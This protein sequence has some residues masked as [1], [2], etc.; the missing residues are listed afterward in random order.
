M[1]TPTARLALS[2]LLALLSACQCGSRL[3]QVPDGLRVEPAAVDFGVLQPGAVA[4]AEVTL[5]NEGKRTLELGFSLE[6]AA[7]GA[8]AVSKGRL[9][10]PS[11]GRQAIGLQYRAGT[12][13]SVDRA[14][15]RIAEGE[16]E[17]EVLLRGQT[18]VPAQPDGGLV[19]GPGP[20]DA[21]GPRLP[22]DAGSC[23]PLTCA[24]AGRTCGAL[25]DGCGGTLSCGA[26]ASGSAC[27][28]QAG[29]CVCQGGARE[30][31]CGDGVD[32]DCDGRIDCVDPDCSGAP[33]CAPTT[34]SNQGDVRLSVGTR[35]AN[36]PDL[37]FDGT[38]FGVAW[39]EFDPSTA[40]IDFAFTRLSRQQQQVGSAVKLTTDGRGAHPPR[41]A[42]SGDWAIAAVTAAAPPSTA[43]GAV[44][45]RRF[46]A[47]GQTLGAPLDT[48]VGWPGMLAEGAA[49]GAWGLLWGSGGIGAAAATLTQLDQTGRVGADLPLLGSA[50]GEGVDYGDL[51]WDGAGWGLVWTAT[52]PATSTSMVRFARITAAGAV[53]VAPL[54]L[55]PSGALYP[56]LAWTGARYGV[57]WQAVNAQGRQDIFFAVVDPQGAVV[58][59]ARNLSQS[60]GNAMLADLTWTGSGFAVA[61]TEE[62]SPQPPQVQLARLDAAGQPTAAV[63]R[64]SC[65]ASSAWRPSVH[66][67][68]GKLAVVWSDSRH[69]NREIYGRILTP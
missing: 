29:R 16:Q 54:I 30:A 42:H 52:L 17:L 44:R 7:P 20:E 21:G 59:P 10:L 66:F 50:S 64:V 13:P 46:T 47:Q 36:A 6:G 60:A 43:G 2:S 28:A 49:P 12:L 62:V 38:D 3:A 25:A 61:W 55:A 67:A 57:S 51:A 23:A 34:C 40:A 4:T 63:E 41:L 9:T 24:S 58:V 8:F 32:D 11:G 19:E 15:L 5:V 48:G 56:R 1:K 53:A 69:P 39:L 45:V 18:Q 26:C 14:Q 22:T 37:A 33:A 35:D 27:D 31:A 68:A 65:S